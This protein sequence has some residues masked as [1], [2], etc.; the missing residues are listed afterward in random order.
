MHQRPTISNFLAIK[1]ENHLAIRLSIFLESIYFRP[2]KSQKIAPIDSITK[3]KKEEF[4]LL[5]ECYDDQEE[6]IFSKIY[7]SNAFGNFFIKIKDS[8]KVKKTNYLKIY[9]IEYSR[10]VEFYLGTFRPLLIYSDSKIIVSDFDKTL[11]DTRYSSTR[12]IYDSLTH[13]LE[14]FPTVEKSVEKLKTFTNQGFHPFILTA[15]PHFYE[16]AIRDWLY[17]H[18]IFT[19]GIFLKDFR[20]A[21]SFI[22]A[23][24][25]P[26]DLK[27]QGF[28][29][30]NHLLN[31]LLMTD[32]PEELVLIGD[33]WESDPSIYATMALFLQNRLEAWQIWKRINKL[34]EF[35]FTSAQNTQILGKLYQLEGMKEVRK[36]ETKV[37]IYIRSLTEQQP[38]K[39]NNELFNPVLNTIELY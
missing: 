11:A 38:L 4:S 2:E 32:I 25:S 10:G 5:I 18:N 13:P 20:Q 22:P 35:K 30:L 23:E 29:K 28:Y 14:F 36:K 8:E 1:T 16:D 39:I 15:S 19:A 27:I 24:L 9:E 33:N 31:I 17:L 26:K 21:L 12:E 6:V 37:S 7:E 34:E 3:L